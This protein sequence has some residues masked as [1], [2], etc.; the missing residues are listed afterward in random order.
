[1][2]S[3]VQKV[4]AVQTVQTVALT[5]D[6]VPGQVLALLPNRARESE[7]KSEMSKQ[8][9]PLERI[10]R[11]RSLLHYSI[12]PVLRSTTLHRYA[13]LSYVERQRRIDAI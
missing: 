10:E 5:P 11:L 1:M 6:Q 4:Q 13:Q 7:A 3:S 12:T 2:I 8:V 9:E